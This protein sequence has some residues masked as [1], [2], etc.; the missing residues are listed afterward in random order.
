MPPE[1]TQWPKLLVCS[2]RNVAQHACA[3][4]ELRL[5]FLHGREL[6]AVG[7]NEFVFRVG[8]DGNVGVEFVHQHS[9]EAVLQSL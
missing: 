8:F 4:G 3:V 6:I 9:R 2:R 5:H 7:V 1:I